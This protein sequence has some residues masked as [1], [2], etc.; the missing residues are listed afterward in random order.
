MLRTREV[1]G[2]SLSNRSERNRKSRTPKKRSERDPIAAGVV[3]MKSGSR[4]SGNSQA[5]HR[6]HKGFVKKK[7]R[8]K[9]SGEPPPPYLSGEWVESPS[10]LIEAP[11]HGEMTLQSVHRPAEEKHAC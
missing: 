9:P 10:K 1:A 4:T 2:I 5:V 8:T 7:P 3:S 6:A 11:K